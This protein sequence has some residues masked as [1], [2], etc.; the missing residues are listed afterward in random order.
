MVA[1]R[2]NC[3]LENANLHET[4]QSAYKKGHSTEMALTR[5]HNGILCAIDDNECVILVL[6]DLSAAFDTVD[7]DILI[8]RLKHRFGI[9]GKALTW[10]KSYLCERTQFVKIGCKRSDNHKLCCGV[11]QSSVLGP[12]LYSMYTAPLADVIS[13]HGM[14][15]RFYADD[16]QTFLSFKPNDPGEPMLSKARVEACIQNINQWMIVNRLILNHEKFKLL[17]LH[18]RH[19]PPP[20]LDS[21][22]VGS[23]TI[24]VSKLAKNIGTWF[25]T[26]MYMDNQI[27]NIC[28][29]SFYHLRNIA[30]ISK[31]IS[32]RHCETLIHAFI[33]SRID[34]C[35]SLLSGRNQTQI[36]RLQH[37][38]NSAARLLTGTRKQEHITPVLKELHWLPVTVRIR[39]K[40]LLM[41]FNCLNLLAPR[42]LT[43]LRTS[44]Q[45]HYAHLLNTC[46]SNHAAT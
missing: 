11:P 1:E 42:Y 15:Y 3:H 24:H 4:F 31:F 19:R 8:E 34:H 40:I 17:I 14:N 27:S 36:K 2:L 39:F 5:I 43:A 28:K 37:V 44:L 38:Q 23:K 33:T 30:Q 22:L 26:V 16:S 35:N 10:I 12:I 6:L 7:H 29:C 20:T 25:D 18:A 13:K 41:A 32:S 45:D 9:T 46:L 21:I